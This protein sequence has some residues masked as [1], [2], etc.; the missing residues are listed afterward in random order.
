MLHRSLFILL[1]SAALLAPAEAVAVEFRGWRITDVTGEATL[2]T[3]LAK[4]PTCADE[5]SDGTETV[6]AGEYVSSFR[7]KDVKEGT[8]LPLKLKPEWTGPVTIGGPVQVRLTYTRAA[9]ETVET[10][11]VTS[12]ENPDGTTSETCSVSRSTCTARSTRVIAEKLTVSPVDRRGRFGLPG[13]R[14]TH[15]LVEWP[16]D[17]FGD[18]FMTCRPSGADLFPAFSKRLLV[19]SL[20]RARPLNRRRATASTRWARDFTSGGASGRLGYEG[21]MKVLR[22]LRRCG[23]P[24][25]RCRDRTF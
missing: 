8:T 25:F 23:G 9:T 20:H 11:H 18:A 21:R 13:P 19:S 12:I 24:S 22:T 7:L 5:P 1:I 14:Q 15:L 4:A 17:A 2:S 6:V 3:R 16:F 10:I